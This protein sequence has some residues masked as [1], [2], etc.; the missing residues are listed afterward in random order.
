MTDKH[1]KEVISKN[2]KALSDKEKKKLKELLEK[3]L[4]KRKSKS[5]R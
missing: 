2:I 1:A 3:E 4:E 5:S